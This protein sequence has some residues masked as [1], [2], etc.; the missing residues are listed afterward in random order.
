MSQNPLTPKDMMSLL[1]DNFSDV[2]HAAISHVMT[3]ENGDHL[4]LALIQADGKAHQGGASS[5]HKGKKHKHPGHEEMQAQATADPVGSVDHLD[6][7]LSRQLINL[8]HQ[9]LMWDGCTDKQHCGGAGPAHRRR[10]HQHEPRVP[11]HQAHQAVEADAALRN[12]AM[13]GTLVSKEDVDG[14]FNMISRVGEFGLN[15]QA[16]PNE[17]GAA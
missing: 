8:L 4:Y 1:Y 2:R 11:E 13:P 10:R 16:V 7:T 14:L 5:D 9:P 3:N 17:E 6:V 12:G 15:S